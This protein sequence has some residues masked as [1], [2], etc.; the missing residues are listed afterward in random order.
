MSS[1]VASAGMSIGTLW[2]VNIVGALMAVFPRRATPA[3]S[4][5]LTQNGLMVM[6]KMSTMVL[7]PAMMGSSVAKTLTLETLE[8]AWPLLLWQIGATCISLVVAALVAW[9]T[10]RP[11][12]IRGMFIA[13]CAFANTGDMPLFVMMI[14]CSQPN[15]SEVDQCVERSAM[16]I[17][18]SVLP[19]QFLFWTVGASLLQP[20]SHETCATTLETTSRTS[21][22]LP[23]IKESDAARDNAQG[24]GGK[25]KRACL[26]ISSVLKKML[27]PIII[28]TVIGLAIA[29]IPGVRAVFYA[30]EE[31]AS[32]V[33]PLGFVS[34]SVRFFSD[35]AVGIIRIFVAATLG[36]RLLRLQWFVS[37]L[38]WLAASVPGCGACGQSDTQ[39][40]SDHCNGSA[41]RREMLESTLSR[42]SFA[43]SQSAETHATVSE[44]MADSVAEERRKSQN[45][46]AARVSID[47]DECME[48]TLV[49]SSR[50]LDFVQGYASTNDLDKLMNSA[51]NDGGLEAAKVPSCAP[52]PDFSTSTGIILTLTR[53]VFLSVVLT[54][55]VYVI[56][57]V[58][59]KG[60]DG[61]F[62]RLI[63][64]TQSLVPSASLAVVV[65]QESG[66]R[67]FAE[68]L[69]A[70]YLAQYTL[71]GVLM[72]ASTYI[73][74]QDT[75]PA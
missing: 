68:G 7:L 3:D 67:T 29:L 18:L 50:P 22:G 72:I 39:G 42:E 73:A 66:N 40:R 20:P 5:L 31:R 38:D 43:E 56:G 21:T 4:G 41:T 28:G 25:G 27:H 70:N 19:W 69:A 75:F 23:P 44:W 8:M 49:E 54:G 74:L 11:K 16:Y 60:D 33:P 57:P 35:P 14:M 26:Y 6:S 2:L 55:L 30:T 64:Y 59:F 52:S 53:T 12:A 58:A 13:A 71:I 63:L 36:K 45:N 1:I 10:C 32:R 47:L 61:P 62:I 34:E 51:S 17:A 9:L 37:A 48:Q 46:T 15:L 24:H 65:S